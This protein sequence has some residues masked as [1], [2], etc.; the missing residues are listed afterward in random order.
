MSKLYVRHA[1]MNAGKSTAILQIVHNYESTDRR[2]DLWTAKVDVRFGEGLVTSRLGP[3]RPAKVFDRDTDFKVVVRD[4]GHQAMESVGA[5]VIDEAQFLTQEQAQALHL[6]AHQFN[7]P[8]MCFLLRTDF[9][10]YPFPGS[11][12]LLSLAE[13]IEEIR[14]T[15]KCGSKATMNIRTDEAG[16]RLRQGPQV[17][18][19]D[20]RYRSVCGDCFHDVVKIPR[21]A[22]A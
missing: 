22:T 4:F 16:N 8:V 11:A 7:V 5:V 21:R 9:Q 15:C 17:L 13:D 14:T 6:A 3:Q 2:V 10:G 19:G 12:M 18:I 20:T 1:P